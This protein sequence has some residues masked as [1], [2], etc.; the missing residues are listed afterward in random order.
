[1]KIQVNWAFRD[2][3]PKATN[4]SVTLPRIGRVPKDG[5]YS[6]KIRKGI[7]NG[8]DSESLYQRIQRRSSDKP[9]AQIA[10]ELG[11]SDSALYQWKKELAEKGAEAFPGSGHQT[12]LQEE[13]RRLK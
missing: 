7:K 4:R 5:I 3:P 10:R 13:N 6:T 12:E 2:V 9:T 1:M 8:K 11:I